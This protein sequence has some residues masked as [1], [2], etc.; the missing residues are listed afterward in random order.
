MRNRIRV[1]P[2]DYILIIS[3]VV[4]L[5]L[6][7]CPDSVWKSVGDGFA[8]DGNL[9]R[10][11]PSFI[12]ILRICAAF[13]FIFSTGMV[14]WQVFSGESRTRF[15]YSLI[16]LPG[17]CVH[18][19]GPFFTDLKKAFRPGTR[20]FWIFLII[21]LAGTIVRLL[22]LSVP[23]E[24][25]EA[26]SMAMW[27]RSDIMFAISDYHL[28]NNH[29]F[30]SFLMNLVY[31]TLGK[32]PALLRL[33][34]FLSGSLTIAAV[35]LLCRLFY[36]NNAVIALTA[37]GLT[38]F[39]PY[40]IF[41]SVN[42]RGYEIQAFLS[43]LTVGLAVYGKRRKNIFAW[44]LLIIF[45]ALN[46][47]T[48]PIAL[49]PFGGICLWLLLNVVFFKPET[50]SF[51]S[52]WLLLKYLIFTGICVS[53]L[54]LLLYVPLFRYS[55]LDSFFGNIYIGGT[56]ASTYGETMM[57]RLKDS[58]E[59]F[60]GTLPHTLVWC[61]AAGI[62]AS[63]FL[64][65]KNSDE[66]VSFGAALLLWMAFLIPFQRPN[67]WPRTVL[68][69]HPFLLMFAASGWSGLRL[70]SG[71]RRLSVYLIG[72]MVLAAGLS[73]FL[74][75]VK[76]FGVIGPDERAVQ[77][78]IDREGD[79]AGSIHF[80]TAAQ[81]NAPLWVYADAYGLP[82]KI[83]DKREAFNTVYAF[84]NPTNDAYLGPLTLDDLLAR[85]G[86]G[87]NFMVLDDPEILTEASNGI[88]YRFEGREGA[89]RKSYGDYPELL[90]AD[91]D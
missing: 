52:R 73:Q 75:A 85:F 55:G 64:F 54:S 16:R 25:D 45:S 38:A 72:L 24:H 20:E 57:S 37:A 28:P 89:I 33:P 17:R 7:L 88:L 60:S 39:A 81:D 82:R 49:Y 19:A 31:H 76:V 9:E 29:V 10:F 83:F 70:L 86:P 84:V 22:Q 1:K 14:L 11:T 69:L 3:A 61:I 15:F 42:A 56:E 18:D 13:G 74:A 71:F 34:V 41:Y 40:L 90:G 35:W 77:L 50:T 66:C 48:L 12:H 26:Y 4:C 65:R 53:I 67:L 2:I 91:E 80:V 27:A 8:S 44:S 59:A 23:L 62:L 5:A 43:V 36:K 6:A 21:F 68:F 63:L 79:N 51:S 78:I 58:V 47:F 30:N 46:F 32:S 87:E